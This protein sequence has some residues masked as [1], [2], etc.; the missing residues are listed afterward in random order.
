[1]K[2]EDGYMTD[3]LPPEKH[4]KALINKMIERD[5]LLPENCIKII[6]HSQGRLEE[7]A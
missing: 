6:P 4:I 7:I 2:C 5:N 3:G 1:M